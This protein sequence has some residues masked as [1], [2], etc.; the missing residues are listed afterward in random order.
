M[1]ECSICLSEMT[2]K[3]ETL[4]CGHIFHSDCI[5]KL[6]SVS[7]NYSYKCPLCRAVNVNHNVTHISI[8]IDLGESTADVVVP[9]EIMYEDNI[10]NSLRAFSMLIV[11]FG[12][13]FSLIYFAAHI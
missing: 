8:D 4:D 2:D 9:A 6:K 10:F 3:T 12:C 13:I 5:S 7:R 1:E 11:L